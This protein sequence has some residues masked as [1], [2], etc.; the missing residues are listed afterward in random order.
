MRGGG[1]DRV[2]DDG[3]TMEER[4]L[5]RETMARA[6]VTEVAIRV[7]MTPNGS[8]RGRKSRSRGDNMEGKSVESRIGHGDARR[9]RSSHN[10]RG[11]KVS[12]HSLDA[13][14][15]TCVSRY[16]VQ[17]TV[18]GIAHHTGTYKCIAH[19][20]GALVCLFGVGNDV[21]ILHNGRNNHSHHDLGKVLAAAQTR[22]NSEWDGMLHHAALNVS[23]K[24]SFARGCT[25][26]LSLSSSASDPSICNHLSGRKV[27]GLG[28]TFGS[29]CMLHA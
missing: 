14:K 27:S 7:V 22:A 13:G 8:W 2:D 1:V 29:R 11:A 4:G 5:D 26:R 3:R 9:A 23:D 10:G 12:L 18:L 28:K 16:R 20:H 24:A 19:L 21:E 17:Q 25:H 15:M 6:S